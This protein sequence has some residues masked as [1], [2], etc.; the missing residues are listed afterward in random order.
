MQV[1]TKPKKL[2]D[3]VTLLLEVKPLAQKHLKALQGKSFAKVGGLNTFMGFTI[4]GSPK[5]AETFTG[6][7][8]QKSWAA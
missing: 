5:N 4:A 3:A 8:L 7:E 2:D 1:I 6:Y